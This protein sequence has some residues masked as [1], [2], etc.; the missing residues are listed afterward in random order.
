M[1]YKELLKRYM[2]NVMNSSSDAFD[3]GASNLPGG[4]YLGRNAS[5]YLS[6]EERAVLYGIS[7]EITT[8]GLFT[9]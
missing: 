3:Q 6:D 7:D 9:R 2:A 8:E 1:D 4:D 5:K